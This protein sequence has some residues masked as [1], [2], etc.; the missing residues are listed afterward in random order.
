MMILS[1][2]ENDIAMLIGKGFT[3]KEIARILGI[4]VNTVKCHKK[5]LFVKLGV[6][7]RRR[8]AVA[9]ALIEKRIELKNKMC[10]MPE[11][12]TR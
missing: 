12:E 5:K 11:L 10:L 3:D 8:A 9:E 4:A 7:R 6:T 1:D 2:R